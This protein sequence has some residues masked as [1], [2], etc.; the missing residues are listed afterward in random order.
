MK[1]I[2]LRVSVVGNNTSHDVYVTCEV[3]E[4]RKLSIGG[5]RIDCHSLETFLQKSE[6]LSNFGGSVEFDTSQIRSDIEDLI[7]NCD[8][9][10]DTLYVIFEKITK[11]YI[12]LLTSVK[13]IDSTFEFESL[14]Q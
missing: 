13:K 1:K 7:E 12:E 6:Y 3:N 9:S 10:K 2:K 4:N 11:E 8:Y 5:R 14:I